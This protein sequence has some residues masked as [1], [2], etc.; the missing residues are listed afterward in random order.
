MGGVE[1]QTSMMARWL[2]AR[3][4]PVSLLTWHEGRAEEVV[5]DEVQVIKMCRWDEGIPGLR[6]LHPQWTS[7]NRAL[8]RADADVYYQNCA[9]SVAGLAGS[10]IRLTQDADLRRRLGEAA[11]A[12]V[13]HLTLEAATD[14]L[15]RLYD[16]LLRAVEPSPRRSPRPEANTSR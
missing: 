14:R 8:R 5:I 3:G 15:M 10:L 2:G 12:S 9:E 16:E 11:R 6:F 7:L 4:F 13:Q 1:R